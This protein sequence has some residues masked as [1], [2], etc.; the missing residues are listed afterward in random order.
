MQDSIL[1]VA[2]AQLWK[3]HKYID[4]K[5]M[6][7]MLMQQATYARSSTQQNGIVTGGQKIMQKKLTH[8]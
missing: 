7:N 1:C 3:D 4:I 8:K 6:L 2:M 5:T